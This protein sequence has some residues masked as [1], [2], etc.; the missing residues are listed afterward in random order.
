MVRGFVRALLSIV[1]YRCQK[2]V[3]FKS[4]LM[5]EAPMQV[6]S[7][8]NADCSYFHSAFLELTDWPTSSSSRRRRLLVSY[9]YQRDSS[10]CVVCV[11][12]S[13][14]RERWQQQWCFETWI[15]CVWCC[16]TQGPQP[17]TTTEKQPCTKRIARRH[18]NYRIRVFSMGTYVI[19]C[20]R[21]HA[22]R[23]HQIS[24]GESTVTH[25]RVLPFMMSPS[26]TSTTLYC[27]LLVTLLD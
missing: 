13:N 6:G 18:Q 2:C 10:V 7:C 16:T 5:N 15:H 20:A 14:V 22:F 4:R 24:I 11:L 27:E 19:S 1:W 8:E 12:P 23:A 26:I 17:A 21:C 25:P 3:W 9:T